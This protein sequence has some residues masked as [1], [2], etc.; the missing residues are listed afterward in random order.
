MPAAQLLQVL[1]L[2]ILRGF[3]AEPLRTHFLC[4][5]RSKPAGFQKLIHRREQRGGVFA[6]STI[7]TIKKDRVVLKFFSRSFTKIH[8]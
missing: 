2:F 8:K 4:G 3:S 1:Q 7:Y 6:E 5:E